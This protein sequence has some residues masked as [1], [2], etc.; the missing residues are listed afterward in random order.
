MRLSRAFVPS[1]GLGFQHPL[2]WR[3][4]LLFCSFLALP[5]DADN[6]SRALGGGRRLARAWLGLEERWGGFYIPP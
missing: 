6:D 5:G 3:R 1:L 2:L 4:G